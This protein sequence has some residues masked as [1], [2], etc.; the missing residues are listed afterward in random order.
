[1][2]WRRVTPLGEGEGNSM[3]REGGAGEEEVGE[4]E[5]V[6]FLH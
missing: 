1:V 2:V 6:S 4:V 5:A 3:E